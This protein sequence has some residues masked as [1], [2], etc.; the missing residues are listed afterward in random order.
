MG[1]MSAIFNVF[2]PTAH[3][4]VPPD[5]LFGPIMAAQDEIRVQ[6]ATTFAKF[7]VTE[8][9]FAVPA[10]LNPTGLSEVICHLLGLSEQVPFDFLVDGQLVRTSLRKH[11]SQRGLSEVK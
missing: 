8:T 5:S 1:G 3:R 7:R 2:R 9:P 4:K 6:F 10:K 11:L